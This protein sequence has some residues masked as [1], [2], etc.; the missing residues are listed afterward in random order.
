MSYR[1]QLLYSLNLDRFVLKNMID[2]ISDE[3]SL[4]PGFAGGNHIKWITGH[5]LYG[6]DRVYA[7]LT[8]QEPDREIEKK[9]GYQTI[10]GD[11]S[12]GYPSIAELREKIYVL[13]NKM[14]D[15]IL[16]LSD[17]DLEKEIPSGD[18]KIK[19]W[20]MLSG[21]IMHEYYHIGQIAMIRT[22]IGL[23]RPFG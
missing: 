23:D 6:A 13:H 21:Y 14:S 15:Y 2:D 5:I 17:D 8:G 12:A 10:P 19:I 18:R 1:E 11:N 7:S 20:Q 16:N 3:N 4:R 9:F 22:A